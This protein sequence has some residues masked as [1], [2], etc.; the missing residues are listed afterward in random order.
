MEIR[1]KLSPATGRAVSAAAAVLLLWLGMNPAAGEALARVGIHVGSSRESGVPGS[2]MLGLR[3]E[4]RGESYG[5][6]ATAL[7][8]RRF[9]ARRGQVLVLSY[10][11]AVVGGA[12]R[13]SVDRAPFSRDVLWNLRIADDRQGEVRVPIPKTG[14][15]KLWMTRQRHAGVY[16]V[17]WR[18]ES[19]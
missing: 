3:R 15:Y 8:H 7:D 17:E 18:L 19:P 13:M 4:L 6:G 16:R 12:L 14:L 1:G 9:L 11:V 2:E 5:A 10:D